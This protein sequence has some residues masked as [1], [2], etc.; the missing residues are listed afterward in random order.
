MHVYEFVEQQ[1]TQDFDYK[2]TINLIF[3]SF[4]A[5][6]NELTI[7]T[8][9]DISKKLNRILNFSVEVP[10]ETEEQKQQQE[11]KETKQVEQQQLIEEQKENTEVK[12]ETT[13]EQE[14]APKRNIIKYMNTIKNFTV[15][16]LN[17]DY[18]I[19]I[20]FNDETQYIIDNI[21]DEYIKFIQEF[22]DKNIEVGQGYNAI[23]CYKAWNGIIETLQ[24]E[25]NKAQDY[26]NKSEYKDKD[27]KELDDML[28]PLKTEYENLEKEYKKD[29]AKEVK[30]KAKEVNNKI[31]KIKKLQSCLKQKEILKPAIVDVCKENFRK[32]FINF[33]Y[34]NNDFL[35]YSNQKHLNLFIK[36][37]KEHE[38]KVEKKEVKGEKEA[39]KEV[40]AILQ[41]LAKENKKLKLTPAEKK[42]TGG[43]TSKVLQEKL[44]ALL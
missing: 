43:G 32:D 23:L 33:L 1:R 18:Q 27:N 21:K 19:K 5:G 37:I 10:A 30:D 9:K 12:E 31:G 26:I 29:K 25:L 28:I 44:K 42:L 15:E 3:E 39:L 22:N 4:K 34:S 14:K 2:N 40:N 38:V 35:E 7:N 13:K 41:R 8:N 17:N 6:E 24:D 20:Y 16:K 11:I 36:L